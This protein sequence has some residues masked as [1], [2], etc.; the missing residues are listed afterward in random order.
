MMTSQFAKLALTI[1]LL[2]ADFYDRSP[3][4]FTDKFGS[5]NLQRWMDCH[6]QRMKRQPEALQ[7][8]GGAQRAIFPK[9]P[10]AT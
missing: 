8:L 7:N 1:Y 9:Q 10:L 2:L 4:S 6:F 3:F 5:D